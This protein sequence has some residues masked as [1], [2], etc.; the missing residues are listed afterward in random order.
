MNQN[1]KIFL[2]IT[3]LF[4]SIYTLASDG[5]RS[6]SDEAF[7]QQQALR[8]V[9]QEPDPEFVLG[10]SG[11]FFKYPEFWYPYQQDGGMKCNYGVLCYPAG[12]VFSASQVPFIF[13]NHHLDFITT[14]SVVFTIEDF[15]DTHYVWWRNSAEPSHTFMQLFYGPF[16]ISLSV[17]IFFLIS[18]AFN[19]KITTSLALAFLLGLSTI[20][21]AY[22]QTSFSSVPSVFFA[23]AGFLYFKKF[24]D[25][26][27]ILYSTISASFLIFGFML[28]NDVVLLIIPMLIFFI[29]YTIKQ[30]RKILKLLSFIIPLAIGYQFNKTIETMRYAINDTNLD[31]YHE[32]IG[33]SDFISDI[34]NFIINHVTLNAGGMNTDIVEGFFGILF[35]PGA[36]LFIYV[37]I[38]LTVFFTFRDFF[39]REKGLSIL[40]IAMSTMFVLEFSAFAYWQGYTA[41]PPKYLL[42]IIPFLLLPLG[43]SIEK[44]GRKIFPII[45]GLGVL[46]FLFN[47]VYIIQDVSWFVW[48][49]PN[50]SG[51][52]SLAQGRSCELYICPEVTWTFQ[53]SPLFTSIHSAL[54]NLHPDVF[55][56]KLLGIQYYLPLAI[57]ILSIQFYVLYRI[58]KSGAISIAE[59]KK[60][61]E[62]D[63]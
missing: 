6:T 55:L 52:M 29:I 17:G 8:I 54:V 44:R 28:R 48:G 59:H 23:L 33:G 63:I 57:S 58:L 36:G 20:F 53:F 25:T 34:S 21:F 45:F 41:F 42:T 9:L 1:T 50:A 46:G 39:K 26:R 38:V 51:L 3:I 47:F 62:R 11:N 12:I 37:P 18:R 19:Y 16:Y 56:L 49:Q 24:L 61:V 40:C 7:A 60:T 14:E 32:F 30:K 22:S 10:E 5:H 43:A 35:S 31:R 15:P 27:K 4:F 13:L 2:V